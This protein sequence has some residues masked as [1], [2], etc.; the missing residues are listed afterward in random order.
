MKN[1]INLIILIFCTT[2]CFS[3]VTISGIVSYGDGPLMGVTII[4]KN[5][6]NGT[7]ANEDGT[8]TLSSQND[9]PITIIASFIGFDTKEII[10]TTS[11]SKNI[12]IMLN[13]NS[14]SL[15]PVVIGASRY[16]ERLL[17][18]AIS[19]EKIGITQLNNTSTADVYEV[20]TS[21]KGVQANTG[22][23]SFTSINARGFSDP[24]NLR[25]IQHIDGIDITTPGFGIIG[26]TAGATE[27]DLRSI[28]LLAGSSSALY[29]PDAFNGMVL[30]YTKNP[31]DYPGFS[32]S[33]K[34]GISKQS[35][36]GNN[37][38]N[39]L[40]LR[41]AHVFSEKVAFKIDAN[42][43]AATDWIGGDMSHRITAKDFSNRD[44]ILAR[45]INTAPFYNAV[46]RYGDGDFGS[47]I[48]KLS[49]GTAVTR[50]GI[51]GGDLYNGD[52]K[53]YRIN[54]GLYY[55][56]NDNWEFEYQFKH[57]HND[58][59]FRITTFYPFENFAQT[60]HKIQAKT[61]NFVARIYSSKQKANRTSIGFLSADLI[62]EDLKSDSQWLADYQ[63]VIDNGGS[64]KEARTFADDYLD[65]NGHIL[66]SRLNDFNQ[67]KEK[68][69]ASTDALNRGS[70]F[71][72]NSG[73]VQ[74]D[75]NY[76]FQNEI[77]FMDVQAGFNYR[78]YKVDSEGSFFNDG[79]NGYG[80]PIEFSQYGG[81][82]QVSK[83]IL[84]DR[85]KFTG[86]I[87]YDKNEN[88]DG[89]ITPRISA[90]Y[91][92]GEDKEHNIRASYQTAFRNPGLQES[93]I[94][95]KLFS[96]LT[97]LG[98]NP[99]NIDN[100][101]YVA[102]S[103][104]TY[105]GNELMA[106]LGANIITP[107]KNKT[108]EVG[109]KGLLLD[110]KLRADISYY[111]TWYPNFLYLKTYLFKP[112]EQDFQVFLWYNNLDQEITSDGISVGLD[113]ILPGNFTVGANYT[114]TTFDAP[115]FEGTPEEK[116]TFKRGLRFNTPENRIQLSLSNTGFG[117]EDNLSFNITYQSTSE[118]EYASSFGETI[119]PKINFTNASFGIKIPKWDSKI[120][121]GGSNIFN[122]EYSYVYGGPNIG[123]VYYV[124]FRY[125][126]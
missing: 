124:G 5:T 114:K 108:F 12:Y 103:G 89:N 13:E 82:V 68:A 15:N 97:I 56:P 37:K 17:E 117:K 24:N 18:S 78:K 70:K 52:L 87:R 71:I 32:A 33:I 98:A 47:G 51:L 61:A 9:L 86:S 123:S 76:N 65:A 16:K 88:Y 57:A 94:A 28:E 44:E 92:M 115:E 23:M 1:N 35:S 73:F 58:F 81:F 119:I 106:T 31:F 64:F 84:D 69:L 101:N 53:N 66:A 75:I 38:Y 25:F 55:R 27:L 30:M 49:D 118:Y 91:S 21:L 105:T 7:T 120:T 102:P 95:F 96:F 46:N 4:E 99:D 6:S 62:Q 10:V 72:D 34:T 11:N 85:L 100:Y 107:E 111:K 41:Y 29:G 14:V 42:H 77:D 126:L 113:Y 79:P 67:A 43:R 125:G 83:K 90:V 116:K 59:S 80:K 8:F 48:V 40:S 121:L 19:I 39:D 20:L 3:Q 110:K 93:F 45:D 109:Y 60:H 54:T 2:Y 36:V 63:S 104:T 22:S 26:N 74:G 50:T 112:G 122:Q